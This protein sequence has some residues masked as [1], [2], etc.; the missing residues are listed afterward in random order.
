[1]EKGIW[2]DVGGLARSLLNGDLMKKSQTKVELSDYEQLNDIL[3]Y[4]LAGLTGHT[5]GNEL[6]SITVQ[7]ADLSAFRVVLRARREVP[8]GGSV[9]VVGFTNASN[10]TS[11][12]LIAEQGYRK[13]AIRWID[14]RFAESISD[15]GKAKISVNELSI[16]D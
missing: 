5:D 4:L 8:S 7:Q 3:I 11:A 15:N 13:N 9:R 6:V 12:L 2:A 16:R 1:M 10:P 14:D